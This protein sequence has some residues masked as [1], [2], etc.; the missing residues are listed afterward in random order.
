MPIVD[1]ADMPIFTLLQELAGVHEGNI[2]RFRLCSSEFQ[3]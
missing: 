3:A 2:A 1:A